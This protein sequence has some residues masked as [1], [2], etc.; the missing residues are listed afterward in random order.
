MSNN[1]LPTYSEALACRACSE[2]RLQETLNLGSQALSGVFPIFD[3]PDPI[4][5]PLVLGLCMNCGL[6]QLLHSFPSE[7]MYGENYGYRSGLNGSMV[8]HLQRKALRLFNEN[9]LTRDSV[10]L[11]IG[12]NDGTLLNA[13]IGT[14]AQ[15]YGM[16]P[17]SKKFAEFYASE[18]HRVEDFFSSTAFLSVSKQAD[19]IFSIAMFYDLDDPVGFVEQIST[20]LKPNG[21]WH[22]EM[23]YLPSMLD[24]NSFDTIC[25]EH[26]EYYSMKSL[27]FILTR[28]GMRIIDV[29]LNDI[30]GGSLAVTAC[31]SSS[32][33]EP[34]KVVDWLRSSENRRFGNFLEELQLFVKRVEIQRV[35]IQT[36]LKTIKESGFSIWGVGAS[37]KGNVLL[38]YCGLDNNIIDAIADVNEFKF[39]RVTPGTHI[40]IKSEEEMYIANPGYA[41]VLPWHFKNTIVGRSEK[42]LDSGGRL[43]FPLPMLSIVE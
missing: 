22:F 28:A 41:L 12:S 37:T 11:D 42:Y 18:V 36:L 33:R 15:L 20:S 19:L 30:N 40:P 3:Q 27:D 31:K 16:D 14:G 21:V 2:P 5:G 32:A 4:S 38:Q 26:V 8:K 7:L 13:L 39:G 1:L 34:K 35:N 6:V 24:S 9:N 29:E 23:S 43:I 17:T 25:H 10:V